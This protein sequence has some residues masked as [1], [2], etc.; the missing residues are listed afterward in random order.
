M[1]L[2]V[3][4]VSGTLALATCSLL[5]SVS[6]LQASESID[7]G[8]NIHTTSLLYSEKGR[9]NIAEAIVD[10]EK[11]IDDDEFISYRLTA[12]TLSGASPNGAIPT[13]EVQTFTSPSGSSSYTTQENT[14]PLDTTFSDT[15][16]S[17]SASWD[18]PL[19]QYLRGV[20]SGSLSSELDY[21]SLGTSASLARDFNQRNTTLSFGVALGIDL[22]NPSCGTPIALSPMPAPVIPVGEDDEGCTIGTGLHG[23]KDISEFLLGLTQ[24]INRRTLM[25]FNYSIGQTSGYMND[26][27]KLVSVID[28]ITGELR[29]IDP[30][31]F[32]SRPDSRKSESLYWRTKHQLGEDVID[33]SYRYFWDD[34]DIRSH[35]VD[36]TYR[37]EFDSGNYLQPHLRYYQQSAASFYSPYA[38]NG[39]IS[40]T[41]SAD[42]RLADMTSTTIGIKYGVLLSKDKEITVAV[43]QM[44]QTGIDYPVDAIGVTFQQD[45]FPDLTATMLRVNFNF[46][47]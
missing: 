6:A 36:L 25:K 43:E 3:K 23:K 22:I 26:P 14:T 11:E 35:T 24:V 34:W 45:L 16:F 37:F 28:G 29:P 27:Y 30:Y 4:K 19:S 39:Q 15:R 21:T 2:K 31:I 33:L 9:V 1:Q 20:F 17:A 7:D 12:D 41:I 47:F 32:E 42:Y 38:V 8:W 40:D 10:A 13:S 18:I 46:I 5:Q 44:N